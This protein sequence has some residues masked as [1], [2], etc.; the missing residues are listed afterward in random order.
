MSKNFDLGIRL[1]Y[2]VSGRGRFVIIKY[3]LGPKQIIRDTLPYIRMFSL[4]FQNFVC[5]GSI[6]SEIFVFK[7]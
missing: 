1:W 5:V 6:L 2:I 3:K 4:H 7:K